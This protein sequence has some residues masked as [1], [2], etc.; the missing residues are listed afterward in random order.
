M[1]TKPTKP[2]L[3][4]T[5]EVVVE[6][7]RAAVYASHDGL[8]VQVVAHRT[9]KVEAML[10]ACVGWNQCEMSKSFLT[11]TMAKVKWPHIVRL[12]V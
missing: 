12:T 5:P 1:S 9:Q 6:N 2:G 4:A 3:A 10:K 8:S 11:P 7:L